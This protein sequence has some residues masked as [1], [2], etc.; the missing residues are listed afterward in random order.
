V[1]SCPRVHYLLS[2]SKIINHIRMTAFHENVNLLFQ[3]LGFGFTCIN[4]LFI[5]R[6]K[7]QFISSI[8]IAGYTYFMSSEV[9]SWA[10]KGLH[11]I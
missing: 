1:I 5:I 3:L 4:F 10:R 9:V 11:E 7:Q 8:S 2:S 6:V